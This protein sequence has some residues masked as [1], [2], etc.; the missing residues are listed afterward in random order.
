MK[1]SLQ[2]N[3]IQNQAKD[4]EKKIQALSLANY[5]HSM[6]L[7]MLMNGFRQSG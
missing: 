5:F 4:T 7:D 2:N 6:K 3:I 1:D